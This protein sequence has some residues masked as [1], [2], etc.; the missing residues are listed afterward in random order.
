MYEIE[1]RL[2][3]SRADRMLAAVLA[4]LCGV[5][6][7]PAP[8][9]AVGW[10]RA[11]WGM[12]ASEIAAAYGDRALRLASPIVFGDSYVKI[13]LRDQI[14]AGYPFRVYFQMDPATR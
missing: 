11:T 4:V 14:F 10:D 1:G 9:A 5:L 7:A 2:S 6:A 12:T 8:A 3:S 13:V